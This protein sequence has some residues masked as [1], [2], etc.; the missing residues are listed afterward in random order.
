MVQEKK[1]MARAAPST[2]RCRQRL[3]KAFVMYRRYTVTV[4]VRESSSSLPSQQK[5]AAQK[6][7]IDARKDIRWLITDC[8][9]RFGFL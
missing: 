3:G 5:V 7:S 4:H 9:V 1:H 2:C 8:K 6:L